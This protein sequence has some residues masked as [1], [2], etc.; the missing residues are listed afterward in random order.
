MNKYTIYWIKQEIAQ[1]YFFK[2]DI[3]YRF[4]TSYQDNKN[5]QDLSIQYRYITHDFD[6]SHLAEHIKAYD[7]H[8]SIKTHQNDQGMTL[9]KN[10]QYM[11]LHIDQ[12]YLTC[13]CTSLHDAEDMLFPILRTFHPLFFIISHT[14]NKYGWISPI[15]NSKFKDRQV[16]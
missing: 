3:L 1:H 7:D 10:N 14:E 6:K 15:T 16:L 5:R 11:L 2:C 9:Y 8:L 13:I 12:S 4:L